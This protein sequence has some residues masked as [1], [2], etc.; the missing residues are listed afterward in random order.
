MRKEPPRRYASAAQFSDDIRRYLEG[1]PIRA[2][3][4]TIAY[5]GSKFISRHRVGVAAAALLVLSLIGGLIATIWQARRAYQERTIAQR[6]F[7]EVRQLAHSLMFEIHDSVQNLAG[8][9]PTR[10]LIVTRALEYLDRLAGEAQNNPTL[11]RELASA[12]EKIGDIQGNP[13]SA[14]LGDTD[15]ALASYQK[16]LAIRS[17]LDTAKMGIDAQMEL[18]RTYR[19]L[20]DILEQKGDVAGCVK[21][22]RQSLVLFQQFAASNG[23][24]FAVQDE[25]A[26]AYETLGDGLART[27]NGSTERLENYGKALAI[28]EQ[29]LNQQPGDRKLRR[30]VAHS[31]L[32]A[33]VTDP[34]K[35]EA[36]EQAQRG[37]RMLEALAAENRDDA[38]AQR[39]VGFAYYELGE[40]FVAA[41]NY[42]AALESRRKAFAI[43]EEIA[44][45][46]PKNAQAA[47]DLA[48]AHA[49][50]A[51]VLAFTD[52]AP[53][54]LHHAQE[55]LTILEQL[56]IAD[57]GNV[58]YRR[59]IALC[60]EKFAQAH[61]H[62]G[63]NTNR[64][65]PERRQDWKAAR[66]N[67]QKAAA[68][69]S[70]LR[71][72]GTLMPSDTKMPEEFAAK[73]AES[74]EAIR[75]LTSSLKQPR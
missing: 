64:L 69:F 34:K 72:A 42:P 66:D 5:R 33:A 15:G 57:P 54:A 14:N 30:S 38:R 18:G 36:V 58:V 9:T 28:R 48:V 41:A 4:D 32:K 10:R 1:L 62:L 70:Q 47:F 73:L 68:I 8:A 61:R 17:N 49:D 31:L 60:Y 21:D 50:L 35:P 29:L 43:R 39:E 56:S 19:G 67:Y 71:A 2:R 74:D 65:I 26:R 20:G 55:S 44:R 52:A 40:I 27:A 7:D 16:A 25:L 12:Y 3:K 22:Y 63:K 6:R 11:Q 13:Y 37:T 53:D 23:S 45:E 51:E 75:Q 46:D 24:E 59:N